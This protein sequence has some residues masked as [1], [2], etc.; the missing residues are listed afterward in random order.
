M[1]VCLNL[2]FVLAAA[3]HQLTLL[4]LRKDKARVTQQSTM[5][6]V[7]VLGITSIDSTL[8]LIFLWLNFL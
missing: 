1:K 8:R 7:A 2:Q 5:G 4:S 6:H 3:A